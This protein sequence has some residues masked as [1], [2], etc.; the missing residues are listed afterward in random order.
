MGPR[1]PVFPPEIALPGHYLIF[2]PSPNHLAVSRKITGD[3]RKRLKEMLR[4]VKGETQGGFIVRTAAEGV[5][6]EELS[7]EMQ[8]LADLWSLVRLKG[9]RATPPASS[10]RRRTSWAARSGRFS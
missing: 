3:E 2:M 6:E 1:G 4:H 9:Q 8:A 10:T 7:G 5:N